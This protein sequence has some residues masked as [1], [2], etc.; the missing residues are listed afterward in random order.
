MITPANM[1]A[2]QYITD[3]KGKKKFVILPVK[4]YQRILEELEDREDVRLYDEAKNED[5]G[6]Y[7]LLS[8]YV[9]KT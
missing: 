8:E 4:E 1:S 9:K 7:M 2:P 5:T 3:V 6:E